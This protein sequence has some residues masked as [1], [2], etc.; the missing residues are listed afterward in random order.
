MENSITTYSWWIAPITSIAALIFARYFYTK[1]L[2]AN[3]GTERMQEI[4]GYVRAGAMA[5]LRRQYAVVIVVFIILSAIFLLLAKNGIQN[6][7]VPIAFLSGGL[8]SGICGYIGMRT[9]TAA[10]NRTAQGCR[11]GLNRGLQVAFRS[12]AVMG[13]VVV[14]FG[15]LDIC[16]WYLVLDKVVFTTQNMAEGW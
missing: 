2:A 15:L 5:Y 14:G 16:I 3:P 12:G 13:L 4:A 7:F 1:M 6:P 9:A 8:F 10:S 11:E